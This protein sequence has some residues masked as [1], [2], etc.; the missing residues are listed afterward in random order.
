MYTGCPSP[1][2][3]NILKSGRNEEFNGFITK[4]VFLNR[5]FVQVI[6][7]KDDIFDLA[8]NLGD[9]IDR[10]PG[11]FLI[12]MEKTNEKRGRRSL[13]QVFIKLF[14]IYYLK[15]FICFFFFLN[16]RV[17]WLHFVVDIFMVKL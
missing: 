3:N 11:L 5:Q 6:N 12:I 1:R 13:K 9:H 8:S 7:V 4:L 10:F 15:I 17:R 14:I 2:I 16:D